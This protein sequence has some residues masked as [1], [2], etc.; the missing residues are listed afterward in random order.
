M[1]LS[2]SDTGCGIDPQT[3]E[4]IFEPFFTTKGPGE[5]TGLGLAT[6][7]GIVKDHDG[8]ISVYSQP[9][10]GTTFNIYFPVH[11]V[12]V[13]ESV[14]QSPATP[15]GRGQ[16]IMFVDDEA[17]L[18]LLGKERLERLGYNVTTHT[19]SVEALKAFHACPTQ[20]DLVITDYTMPHLN[21]DDLAIDMLNVRPEMPVIMLTGYS[22]TMNLE[23]T[24]SIGIRELLIKPTTAQTIGQAVNR[25]LAKKK[26]E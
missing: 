8:A 1:R 15:Q 2:V 17:P 7:Y 13:P 18:A 20:F 9:G 11:E 22:S 10:E 3:I 23:R 16:Q 14:I 4:R 25:A 12:E 5:G 26:E 21:G 24:T 6:V 19:S